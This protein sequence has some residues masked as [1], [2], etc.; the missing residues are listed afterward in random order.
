[1]T[2]DD[3]ARELKTVR[4]LTV[5]ERKALEDWIIVNMLREST[6]DVPGAWA[7]NVRGLGL[8]VTTAKAVARKRLGR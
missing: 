3:I 7:M 5:Y 6:Y 8:I 2:L 4:G 1:M